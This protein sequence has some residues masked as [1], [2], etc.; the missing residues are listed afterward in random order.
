MDIFFT[1]A[2]RHSYGIYREHHTLGNQA[3]FTTESIRDKKN[4]TLDLRVLRLSSKTE[5]LRWIGDRYEIDTRIVYCQMLVDSRAKAG[6]GRER[7]GG[8][9]AACPRKF[10]TRPGDAGG[11]PRR[12]PRPRRDRCRPPTTSGRTGNK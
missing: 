6:C 1:S 4:K 3:F 12:L 8:E 7:R 9:I 11:R 5:K 10:L 2:L